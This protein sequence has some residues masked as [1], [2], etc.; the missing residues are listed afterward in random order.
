MKKGMKIKPTVQKIIA[1]YGT[2]DPYSI[3]DQMGIV[4]QR[5]DLGTVRGFYHKAFRIR[6]IFLN[7]NLNEREELFVTS[8]ELGHAVLHPDS[9]TP[10][11]KSNTYFSVNKLEVEANKFA[12]ELLIPDDDL[13]EYKDFTA[14]QV[15]NIYGIH[16]KMLEL[17]LG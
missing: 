15:A 9:N 10:F 12:V 8:H 1:K 16:E 3:A 13:K 4:I 7:E 6:Q 14:K 17:R 5:Q 11:L 2:N